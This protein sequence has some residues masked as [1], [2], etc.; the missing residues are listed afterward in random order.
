MECHLQKCR[1]FCPG[2]NVLKLYI[3]LQSVIIMG[4]SCFFNLHAISQPFEL[5]N[6][7]FSESLSFN[8][9]QLTADDINIQFVCIIT[10]Y[11]MLTYVALP[12]YCKQWF[13][14]SLEDIN[15]HKGVFSC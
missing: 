9:I 6:Y 4:A 5:N 3:E 11:V 13:H 12:L 15:C 7:D 1:A 14:C 8:Q 2:F 10:C